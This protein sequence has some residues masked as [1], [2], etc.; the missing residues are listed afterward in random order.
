MTTI[1]ESRWARRIALVTAVA[2]TF[3]LVM[4]TGTAL[5]NPGGVEFD[6]TPEE[7]PGMG[8]MTTLINWTAWGVAIIGGIAFIA[9]I[10][11]LAVSVFSGQEIRAGKGMII[12]VGALILLGA[13]G[14]IV[15]AVM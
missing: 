4:S 11:W 9:T 2:L 3:V 6:P 1:M 13:A 10:G 14:A 5:A 12:T 7:I 8:G 15:G